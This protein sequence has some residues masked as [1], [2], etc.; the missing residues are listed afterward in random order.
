[1]TFKLFLLWS[2]VLLG[3]P[4]DFFLAL[5]PMRPALLLSV[6]NVG[7]FFFGAGEK[8]LSSLFRIN[9]TRKYMLF[10]LVMIIGIPFAYHRR[11]AFE[12]IFLSYLPNILFFL[13]FLTQVNSFKRLKSIVLVIS[14]C[15][16]F[17]SFFGITAGSF[18]QGRFKIYGAMFDPNDIAYVLISLFPLSFFYIVH[19]EGILKKLLSI[20]SIV[21]SLLV[22]LYS[23]SR[24]GI[25][26]LGAVL[27]SLL[28]TRSGNIKKSYKIAFLVGGMLIFL[29]NSEKINID[30]YSTLTE[31]G[32]DYNVTDEWGRVQI[33]ER[34]FGLLMSNPVTGVGVGC[35]EMAIGYARE[36]AG[37]L[38]KWQSVHNSFIQIAVET[39]VIGFT[40]FMILVVVSLKEFSKARKMGGNS[41]EIIQFK[42]IAGLIYIEFVG[43]LVTA[44]FLTQG[45]SIFFTFFFALSVALRNIS[46]QLIDQPANEVIV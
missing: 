21:G 13:I 16:F 38:P 18:V 32:S 25:V 36:A 12:Y 28:L 20:A 27:T 34:A 24:G 5:Q 19:R 29:L 41:D 22:I 15:V 42:T 6:I 31:V 14:L 40:L 45:Y 46:A 33:W 44:F 30:R 23:G 8:Q 3:R 2:F 39:G 9:E 35:S 17:Y 26:G 7:A 1:M 10:Y 43:H 11:I 4:Q 37:V